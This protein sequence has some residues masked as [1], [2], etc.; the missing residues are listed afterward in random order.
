M[1]SSEKLMNAHMKRSEKG[2]SLVE[3]L[4]ALSIFIIGLL[5]VAKVLDTSIQYTSS[6]RLLTE[7]TEIAQYQMEE[8]MS[9]PYNDLDLDESLSP[10][11][12]DSIGHY[13]VSW[14]VQDNVPLSAMK[15]I[16][17][18]VAWKDQGE[19]KNLTVDFLKQ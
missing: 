18:T 8:L 19:S 14:T 9:A 10:Y 11:G 12:P 7:A 17:L 5:A 4:V 15:T 6:A 1:P 2:F 3:V 16:Q 13:R